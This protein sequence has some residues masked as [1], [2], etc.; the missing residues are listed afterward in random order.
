MEG[1]IF[2]MLR[3]VTS[4]WSFIYLTISQLRIYFTF[5]TKVLNNLNNLSIKYMQPSLICNKTANLLYRRVAC[6][7]FH[8]NV[9]F[10]I[11]CTRSVWTYKYMNRKP[12]ALVRGK[13]DHCQN[14]NTYQTDCHFVNDPVSRSVQFVTLNDWRCHITLARVIVYLLN[15]ISSTNIRTSHFPQKFLTIQSTIYQLN[16]CNHLNLQ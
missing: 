8:E 13:L 14:T 9:T 10:Y 1:L 5:Y 2:R 12:R 3:Y 4:G 6:K 11:Q 7:H 15:N 16:T